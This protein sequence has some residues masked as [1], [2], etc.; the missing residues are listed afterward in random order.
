MSGP[1]RATA[2]DGAPAPWARPRYRTW[3][4]QVRKVLLVP[5]RKTLIGNG[6]IAVGGHSLCAK[7]LEQI[8]LIMEYYCDQGTT[9]L[10]LL[11]VA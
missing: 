4:W 9:M 7:Q 5:I 3:D 8:A 11:S 2:M 10:L 1:K 6:M